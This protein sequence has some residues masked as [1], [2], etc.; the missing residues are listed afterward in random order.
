MVLGWSG[1]RRGST[2]IGD[3][4]RMDGLPF[5]IWRTDGR[6]GRRLGAEQ[7]TDLIS[8]SEEFRRKWPVAFSVANGRIGRPQKEKRPSLTAE[9][10][11]LRSGSD[12]KGYPLR[13]RY[14]TDTG[15]RIHSHHLLLYGIARLGWA[16]GLWERM[17]GAQPLGDS[18]A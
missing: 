10:L 13:Q 17:G 11:S 14:R 2:E 7:S 8:K 16:M 1:S 3:L 6:G 4:S 5:F 18:F 15:T 12:L 9:A